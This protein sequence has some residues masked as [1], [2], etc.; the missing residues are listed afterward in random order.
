MKIQNEETLK[1]FQHKLLEQRVEHGLLHK[2]CAEWYQELSEQL[3]Q[4]G[5]DVTGCWE[6]EQMERAIEDRLS[7]IERLLCAVSDRLQ[8]SLAQHGAVRGESN[9]EDLAADYSE[10]CRELALA[11]DKIAKLQRIREELC[12][13][14]HAF[15]TEKEELLVRED[16]LVALLAG[17]KTQKAALQARAAE[18]AAGGAQL[19]ES[20]SAAELQRA[21]MEA[22]LDACRSSVRGLLREVRRLGG[23]LE[24]RSV[25]ALSAPPSLLAYSSMPL[26]VGSVSEFGEGP[27]AHGPALA[28]PG[29][30]GGDAA[31]LAAAAQPIS[32]AV[33]AGCLELNRLAGRAEAMREEMD[34]LR[35]D[36]AG[37]WVSALGVA[38]QAEGLA[39]V[40]GRLERCLD[41]AAGEAA[42]SRALYEELVD[43]AHGGRGGLQDW[44]VENEEM[45]RRLAASDPLAGH[46]GGGQGPV[47]R[48]GSGEE[49]GGE[50]AREGMRRALVASRERVAFLAAREAARVRRLLQDG[51][52]AAAAVP[53][54]GLERRF[55]AQV[56][57]GPRDSAHSG[58]AYTGV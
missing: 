35:E 33:R 29:S 17:E 45:A 8:S 3:Q 11:E 44:C 46:G 34:A 6:H 1:K 26:S 27:E 39:D 30:R 50:A 54:R 36:R 13:T 2:L 9:Q 37:H 20:A 22:E 21:G 43:L 52:G 5:P 10:K 14:L 18:L 47:E 7:D 48:R 42:G 49:G 12:D 4:G 53:H 31:P 41:L 32:A 55:G 40:V 16:E 58:G 56:C 57:A 28:L 24:P 15:L 23:A 51:G 25:S 38:E 19:A